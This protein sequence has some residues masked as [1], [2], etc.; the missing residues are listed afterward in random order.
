[1]GVHIRPT[2]GCR[3]HVVV[4][5]VEGWSTWEERHVQKVRREEDVNPFMARLVQLVPSALPGH[6]GEPK[7]S[8]AGKTPRRISPSRPARP[9]R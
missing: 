3:V 9:W 2:G 4:H 8:G 6:C 1:M 5:R 7:V